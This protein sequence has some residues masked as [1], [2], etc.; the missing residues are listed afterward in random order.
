MARTTHDREDL[1]SDARALVPRVQLRV[2]LGGDESGVFAGF[3][4]DAFSLYF[5]ADPAYHFNS[6]GHLRRAYVGDRL[7]K[8]EHGLLA[9][10]ERRQ[11]A[12]ATELVRHD[13]NVDDQRRLLDEVD[14]RLAE[15]KSAL[16]SGAFVVEGQVPPNKDAVARLVAWLAAH[17]GAVAARSPG[18]T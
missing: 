7:I 15:L 13:L 6:L 11:S 9:A 16:A 5:G 17:R 4:G 8:A 12:S 10:L 18:V 2:R 14:R 1:L 3:R